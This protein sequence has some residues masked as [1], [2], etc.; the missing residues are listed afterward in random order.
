MPSGGG[1][2]AR[3]RLGSTELRLIRIRLGL[4]WLLMFGWV[5]ENLRLWW[6]MTQKHAS[7]FIK[8]RLGTVKS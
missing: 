4:V 1:L 7:L 3:E 5:T 2:Y 8:R 6:L